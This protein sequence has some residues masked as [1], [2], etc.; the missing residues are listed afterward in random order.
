[1]SH[2]GLV[3]AFGNKPMRMATALSM[4]SPS[5]TPTTPR[6][7][8]PLSS[9]V[10]HAI[11]KIS[12]KSRVLCKRPSKIGLQTLPLGQ[13]ATRIVRVRRTLTTYLDSRRDEERDHLA[14]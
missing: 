5:I 7:L 12:L 8:L 11:V 4:G 2:S 1:M 10:Y 13:D 14:K 9:L 3:L 6:P